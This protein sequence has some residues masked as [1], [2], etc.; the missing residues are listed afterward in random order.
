MYLCVLP[1]NIF[2][3]VVIHYVRISIYNDLHFLLYT[4]IYYRVTYLP[5]CLF[6]TYAFISCVNYSLYILNNLRVLLCTCVY[7]R[8]THLPWKLFATY[9]FLS[10]VRHALSKG[11]RTYVSDLSRE[12]SFFQHEPLPLNIGRQA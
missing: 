9:V 11:R 1:C 8:V 5:R 7:N 3:T 6:T 10:C 4:F 12:V 2:T